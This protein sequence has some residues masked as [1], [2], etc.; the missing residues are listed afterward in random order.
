ME[1]TSYREHKVWQASID[2]AAFV[3][4]MA[5]SFPGNAQRELAS[6]LGASAVA[7]PSD[8]ASAWEQ[9][10]KRK[11]KARFDLVVTETY[12]LESLIFL[13]ARLNLMQEKLLSNTFQVIIEI[14]RMINELIKEL[15]ESKS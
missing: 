10:D 14:R 5:D 12:R 2:L 9:K 8:I 1:K 6:E 4:R 7:I 13:A 3:I 11:K 15:M